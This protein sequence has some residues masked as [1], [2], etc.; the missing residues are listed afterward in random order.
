LQE[1]KMGI[2]A[3]VKKFEDGGYITGGGK[4]ISFTIL[5]EAYPS[6]MACHNATFI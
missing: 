3:Y 2:E 6:P 1:Q 4:K 5:G